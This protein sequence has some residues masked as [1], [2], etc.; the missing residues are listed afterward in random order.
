MQQ[1]RQPKAI[2]WSEGMLLSPQHFQQNNIYWEAQLQG[3]R[4]NLSPHGWGIVELK[5]DFGKLIQVEVFI[6]RLQA[7]M[8][9]G[10][11][12]NYDD[13]YDSELILALDEVDELT[14]KSRV[15]VHLIV[16]IRVPGSAS[17]KG[18]IQ[19]FESYDEEPA[20]DDN[21]GE[22]AL[23]I[24]R[25]K[26]LL[27]LKASDNVSKK[28][29]SLP[30]FEVVLPD[31]GNFQLGSYCPPMLNIGADKFRRDQEEL[32]RYQPLQLRCQNLAL[33]L[34]KKAR[35]LAGFNDDGGG[36]G[37][38]VT[39]QHRL[40]IRAMVKE[41]IDFELIADNSENTPFSLYQSVARVAAAMSELDPCCIPPKLPKYKHHDILPG[42][43]AA[44]EY[45][46]LQL[47]RVNLNYTTITFDEG[48]SGIFSL[49]YDKAWDNQDLLIELIANNENN[50]AE[51]IDWF[52]SCRVASSKLHKELVRDRLLG[53][54][55]TPVEFDEKTGLSVTSRSQLF[56]VKW[57]SQYIKLGQQLVVNCTNEKIKY[58][59][60]KFI[61]LH[62]AHE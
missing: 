23:V 45:I 20:V 24:S 9:D 15:L 47:D 51:L 46:N 61:R 39:A 36:L 17:E 40:W 3:L 38:R 5:I 6:N 22:N 48:R 21:T 53:A 60:P 43:N 54:K 42:F 11:L 27:S 35:L 8:P 58:A 2:C 16:P 50:K 33:A 56:K 37:E 55:V 4:A 10:L 19:R 44:L 52:E 32:S 29:I 26:P 12:I 7:F 14:E 1:L 31:E 30:L 18:I 25:L 41:L 13:K 59:Q 57:D 49:V 28:Y 34:R 62:L